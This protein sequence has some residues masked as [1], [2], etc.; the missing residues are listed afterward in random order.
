[1]YVNVGSNVLHLR[2]LLSTDY[3]NRNGS[4]LISSTWNVSNS[5]GIR[6]VRTTALV[7]IFN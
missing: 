2:T 3:T 7:L 1:M 4:Q 5:Y 6:F